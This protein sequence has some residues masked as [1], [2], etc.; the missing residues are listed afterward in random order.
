MFSLIWVNY[1]TDDDAV[2]YVVKVTFWG[3]GDEE[4][5]VHFGACGSH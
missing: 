1:M 4:M 3:E 5:T 2:M